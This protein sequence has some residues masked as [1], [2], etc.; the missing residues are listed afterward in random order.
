M[1]SDKYL[2]SGL[3]EKLLRFA[4]EVTS[5]QNSTLVYDQYLQFG[6]FERFNDNPLFGLE[7]LD[8]MIN[9]HATLAFNSSEFLKIQKETLIKLLERDSLL[10]DECELFSACVRWLAAEVKRQKERTTP[11]NKAALFASFK[12]L[13]RFP[14]MSESEFFGEKAF[15]PEIQMIAP[16]KSNLFTDEELQEFRNYFKSKQRSALSI[17]YSF[18]KRN[19]LRVA[20]L[21]YDWQTEEYR[22]A[23]IDEELPEEG[24]FVY[25]ENGRY[26]DARLSEPVPQ[27]SKKK[28]IFQ[29][30]SKAVKQR[31]GT[32]TGDS[33]A[34]DGSVIKEN[35]P[36]EIRLFKVQKV[37]ELN[38]FKLVIL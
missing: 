33:V 23:E 11:I 26:E 27:K 16:A 12:H 25:F 6:I 37:N 21:I 14:L 9:V 1:A 4:K 36:D 19:G 3:C 35:A 31:I 7:S 32:A 8:E 18:E 20:K 34:V 5:P 24:D 30:L 2:V 29:Q 13:I 10:I 38:H 15:D 28:T 17:N 22:M